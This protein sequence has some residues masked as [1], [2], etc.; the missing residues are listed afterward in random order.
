MSGRLRRSSGNAKKD[1]LARIAEAK[2]GGRRQLDDLDVG[3][4]VCSLC[5]FVVLAMVP[6]LCS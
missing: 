3:Y 2:K 5:V 1:A 4:N 6:L